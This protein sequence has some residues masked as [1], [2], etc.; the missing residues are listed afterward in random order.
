MR[1]IIRLLGMVFVLMVLT[2]CGKSLGEYNAKDYEGLSSVDAG[3]K[4]YHKTNC[5][6]CHSIDGSDKVGG[7]LK[8]IYLTMVSFEGGTAS[9]R[10]VNYLKDS[11]LNPQNK[12]VK[13]RPNVM[14]S[15]K[16]VFKGRE[17]ELDYLI[18][19]I[20]SLK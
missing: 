12:I 15:Y 18:D 3:K 9:K 11:I 5:S 7:A 20:K 19:Y 2:N 14:T 1:N 8:G 4:V 16:D 10:D 13:G 17:Q 6:N